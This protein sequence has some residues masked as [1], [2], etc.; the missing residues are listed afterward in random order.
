MTGIRKYRDPLMDWFFNDNWLPNVNYTY[1][2]V[3]VDTD[4]YDIFPKKSYRKELI[5]QKEKEI[6]ALEE[7]KKEL[8]DDLEKL[9][10]AD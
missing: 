2:G 8:T 1:N 6:A 9:R 7:K 4:K 5:M 10:K 3:W